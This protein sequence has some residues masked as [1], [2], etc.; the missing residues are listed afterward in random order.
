MITK[1][2][3]SHG[4]VVGYEITGKVSLEIE[5][6]WIAE[7]DQLLKEHDK[8]NVLIVLGKNS[9]WEKDAGIAD[10]KW[11]TKHVRNFDK[12][13]VVATGSVWKWLIAVDSFFAKMTGIKE[14]YFE[15][16]LIDE[17]WKWLDS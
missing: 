8:I 3:E 7:L 2:P 16:S 11:I 12:I 13:A 6:E 10:I 1:L 4:A 9:R 17:A 15:P 14:K 5:N